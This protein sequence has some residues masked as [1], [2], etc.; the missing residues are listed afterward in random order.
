MINGHLRMMKL[1]Q[2]L[3]LVH[4]GVDRA[5]RD[6]S[7]LRHFFHS[8]K[9]LFLPELHFPDFSEAASSDHVFEIKVVLIALCNM[10]TN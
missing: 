7:R 8:E 9:L 4:D 10:D 2:E 6:D 1:T 5:L 3:L